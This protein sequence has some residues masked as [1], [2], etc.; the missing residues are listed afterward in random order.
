MFAAALAVLV[1]LAVLYVNGKLDLMRYD[2]G[3][4]A[5]VG[6]VDAE[7]DQDLDGTGLTQAT[8][9]KWRCRRA[10][11]LRTKMC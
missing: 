2:D 11:P 10:A 9:A 3:S 1:L 8:N 5:R 6:I 4:V 7:E